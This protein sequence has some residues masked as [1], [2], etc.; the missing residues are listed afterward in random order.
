MQQASKTFPIMLKLIIG[1]LIGGVNNREIYMNSDIDDITSPPTTTDNMGVYQNTN[2]H[3]VPTLPE[4]ARKVTRPD[5]RRENL[6]KNN[7]LHMK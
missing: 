5:Q 4:T 1:A 3:K 2:I 6:T 7:T